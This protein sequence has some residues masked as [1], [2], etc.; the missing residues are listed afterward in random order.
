MHSNLDNIKTAPFTEYVTTSSEQST[1]PL[2]DIVIEDKVTVEKYCF[3]LLNKVFNLP[4]SKFPKFI[5]YQTDLVQDELKWLNKFEKL[6]GLNENLFLSGSCLCR[7]NKMLHYIE[8]KRDE[9]Q[10][11]RV[12]AAKKGTPKRLIN[13]E[14]EDRHFSFHEVKEY[15]EKLTDFDEKLIY[16]TEE[17]F[18][19]KQADI[20]YINSKLQPYNDQCSFLIEKLQTIRSMKSNR[21]KEKDQDKE[22]ANS[23]ATPKM[24]IQLNGPINIITNA[25]KQ[26]MVNVKPNGTAYIPYKIKDVAQFICDNFVDENGQPLSQ[27]TIQTYLSP[28]RTDKDPNSDAAVK[29]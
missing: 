28:N 4:Q 10:S 17:I 13:A 3:A 5:N 11:L 2:L 20:I 15:V 24:Q 1:N 7:F 27:A 21:E 8:K 6:L 12:R 9:V 26:M 23:K 19:Y 14:A 29:F 16:L 25:F 18:E 22:A